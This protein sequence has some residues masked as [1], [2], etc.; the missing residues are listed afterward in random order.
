MLL[1]ARTIVYIGRGSNHKLLT[2]SHLKC[3]NPT[4]ILFDKMRS[5]NTHYDK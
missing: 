2:S 4:T 3:I 5:Y 1:T